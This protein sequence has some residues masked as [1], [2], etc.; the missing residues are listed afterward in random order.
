VIRVVL[1]ATW[2]TQAEEIQRKH[3]TQYVSDTTMCQTNTN[4]VHNTWIVSYVYLYPLLQTTV[5]NV[6]D[7]AKRSNFIYL[8][9]E[10]YIIHNPNT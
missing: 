10:L 8:F 6:F 2:D 9:A 7:F 5:P 4:N 1:L 3:T